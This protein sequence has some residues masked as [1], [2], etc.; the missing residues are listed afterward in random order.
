MNHTEAHALAVELVEILRPW[1]QR[2]EIAG[3]LRRGKPEVKD[4][5]IVTL[6]RTEERIEKDMFG[7][8]VNRE[9][10]N[11]TSEQVTFAIRNSDW[12]IGT[13]N[14]ERY[15]QLDYIYVDIKCDLFIVPDAREWG[16]LYLIRTGPAEFNQEL[17]YS[18]LRKGWH[19][20]GN[21]LHQHG[22]TPVVKNGKK[23]YLP[24]DKG[25]NCPLIA[26][27]LTEEAF[28]EAVG[29]PWVEPGERSAE[30]LKEKIK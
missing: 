1:C 28:L 17:M 20:T 18:I 11:I 16:A 6:A 24:C 30:W 15:K 25:A 19:L 8:I 14:G 12:C 13:R 9:I 26:P 27:T 10:Y 2:I 5:E 21:L 3:S 22:K 7:E 23:E 29:L 4:I